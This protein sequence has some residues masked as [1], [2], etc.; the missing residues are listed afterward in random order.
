MPAGQYKDITEKFG[1]TIL[2]YTGRTPALN[3]KIVKYVLSKSGNSHNV[4]RNIKKLLSPRQNLAD[5]LEMEKP[6]FVKMPGFGYA[7]YKTMRDFFMET[8]GVEVGYP[9]GITSDIPDLSRFSAANNGR[10]YRNRMN[11]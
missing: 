7:I 9:K 1:R 8:Y 5:I 6:K 3:V 4:E 11:I 2:K 10:S